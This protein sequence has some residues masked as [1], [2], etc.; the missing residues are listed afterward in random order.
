MKVGERMSFLDKLS[1][2]QI[3]DAIIK[4]DSFAAALNKLGV[5]SSSSINRIILA[6]YTKDHSIPCDHFNEQPLER[7]AKDI[8]V[9]HSTAAQSTLRKHYKRGNYSEY[10]CSIC[11]LAPFWNGQELVLTLD[12]IN[13][14]NDD[15]RLENLRWICPNCDMQLPTHGSKRTKLHRVCT[16]CGK[17]L[18]GKR[19]SNLCKDCYVDTVLKDPN[20]AIHVK[21]RKHDYVPKDRS[22]YVDGHNVCKMCGTKISKDATYCGP[23]YS[24][25]R[26]KTQRPDPLEL[27]KSIKEIGFEATG[28]R[29]GVGGNAVVKWCK[30]YG[31]PDKKKA[32]IDWYNEQMGIVP[33]PKPIRKKIDEIVRPVNQIDKT[34]GE[35]LNTFACQADALRHL[36]KPLNDNHISEVCRGIRKSAHGYCWEYAD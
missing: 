30:A 27:A 10:K 5:S 24:K 34:T 20:N 1:R 7:S 22:H 29:F 31:M 23:C 35:V 26:M 21:H 17:E 15:H 18:T 32:V 25:T 19:K 9:E 36:G 6:R 14:V 28:K 2:E 13:G 3:A 4:S 11:N 12:H 16:K 8:F 33:E